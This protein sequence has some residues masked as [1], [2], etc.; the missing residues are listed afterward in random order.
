MPF[1]MIV[2]IVD[3]G[4]P[5]DL[6]RTEEDSVDARNHRPSHLPGWMLITT[7]FAVYPALAWPQLEKV[8][9]ILLMIFVTLMLMQSKERIDQLVWVIALSLG[10]YGV[11]GG[12]FT[13]ANGGVFHVQRAGRELHRRGQRD[14]ACAGHDDS[15]AALSAA[16]HDEACGSAHWLIAAMV[17]SALAAVGSQSRGALL[18]IVAM[19][20]FLWLKSRNKFVYGAAGGRRG[21]I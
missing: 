20:T 14:G 10:F 5:V 4:R 6:A 16:D 15:A 21:R 8:A 13:I 7:I 11:K 3:A 17:L 9:K 1:A 12:I 19:G 18:G 2:A